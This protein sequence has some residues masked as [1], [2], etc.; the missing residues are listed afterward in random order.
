MQ[1][2][3]KIDEPTRDPRNT[4]LFDVMNHLSNSDP[5]EASKP[6]EAHPEYDTEAWR[7]IV[8]E[9]MD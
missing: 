1:G 2:D 3:F 6:T 4:D 5:V 9:L 8:K 7:G